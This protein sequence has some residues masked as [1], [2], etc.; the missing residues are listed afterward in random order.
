VHSLLSG[1][2]EREYWSLLR[3]NQD[4]YR[5]NRGG[6]LVTLD[7][8][9]LSFIS[10]TFLTCHLRSPSLIFLTFCQILFALHR[11]GK[12]N[13][14]GKHGRSREYDGRPNKAQKVRA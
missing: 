7:L 8:F 1:E 5:G 9:P 2:A 10:I 14:G 13:R 3:G 11:G 4:R 6:R 12:F